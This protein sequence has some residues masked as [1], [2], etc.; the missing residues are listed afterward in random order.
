MILNQKNID[1]YGFILKIKLKF[2][3][4]ILYETNEIDI[5]LTNILQ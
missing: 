4:L 3:V 2:W 1:I 5:V